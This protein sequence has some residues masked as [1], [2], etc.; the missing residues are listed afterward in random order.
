MDELIIF[1]IHFFN[2]HFSSIL[3]N[4]PI[5]IRS[6][7]LQ[8]TFSF[9]LWKELI[10]FRS[11]FVDRWDI[12]MKKLF[13]VMPVIALVL[14]SPCNRI[15]TSEVTSSNTINS[16]SIQI[17][18]SVSSLPKSE[19]ISDTADVTPSPSSA[20]ALSSNNSISAAMQSL[21]S[22]LLN[23]EPFLYI[24]DTAARLYRYTG[25]L[26]DI[27]YNEDPMK[28]PQFTIIDLDGDDIPEVVLAIEYYNGFV[29]LKYK[30][31]KVTGNFI[32]YRAFAQLRKDG[33]FISSYGA[34]YNMIGK[35]YFIGDHIL[36]EHKYKSKRNS[37][38]LRDIPTDKEVW[39]NQ[40]NSFM[41]LPEVNCFNNDD[42]EIRQQFINSNTKDMP[43]AV[44]ILINER[45][46][47]L[48]SLSKLIDLT[49]NI[50]KSKLAQNTD[51]KNYY[52]GCKKQMKKFYKLC[53]K[54]SLSTDLQALKKE[55]QQWKNSF[56][57]IQSDFL[58]S[59]HVDSIDELEEQYF[60]FDLGDIIL[61]RTIFLINQYYDYHFYD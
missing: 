15:S 38:F 48:D 59:H 29:I 24:D 18:P 55:Q 20:S 11:H 42:D 57:K 21:K 36:T 32:H 3:W 52:K 19:K 1:R 44:K 41:A 43:E 31:N 33:S 14:L 51:A 27:N 45:Q 9:V 23:E 47:N 26:K 53:L 60:Y 46:E 34:D 22:V 56:N 8:V 7:F 4:K 30:N 54:K 12:I 28:T 49:N 16:A 13:L 6:Y 5:I 39:E 17:S 61:R 10:K 35:I 2:S 37:Y 25:Y 58:T 50:G 40:W